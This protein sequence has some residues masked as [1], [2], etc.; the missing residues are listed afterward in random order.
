M[1]IRAFFRT[2]RTLRSQHFLML[3]FKTA[4]LTLLVFV[5]FMAAVIAGLRSYDITSDSGLEFFLDVILTFGAGF[6]GWL[7]LPV[8]L[9]AIAAFFQETIADTIERKDYPEFVP[10]AVQRPIWQE[11]VEDSRFILLML[12][13]NI[14]F[15]VTY[16]IPVIGFFTYYGVNGYLIGR[17]FFDTAAARHL[18]RANARKLRERNPMP[19]FFCGICIVFCTNVPGLNLVAPFIGVALMVHLYHLLDKPQEILPPQ[20]DTQQGNNA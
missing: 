6:V 5:L 17:E 20:K 4:M 9:P 13:A 18:G 11:L 2:F 7:L 14:L 8:M 16:F 19:A 1:F 3:L 15:F 10:P 12:G